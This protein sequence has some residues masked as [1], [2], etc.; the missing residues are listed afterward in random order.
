M[1]PREN[2]SC[3]APSHW[4][5]APSSRYGE[6]SSCTWFW[7]SGSFFRVSKQG[8]CFAAVEEE[9]GDKRPVELEP[10]CKADDVAP[11]DPVRS[12]HCCHAIAEAI[13]M[14][15]SAEQVPYL[16]MVAPSNSGRSCYYLHWCSW[17][18][19]FLCWPSFH[20]SSLCLRVCWWGLEVHHWCRPWD[21]WRQ[22]VGWAWAIHQWRWICGGHGVFP[23]WSSLGTSWTRWV[24]VSIPDGHLLLSRRTTWQTV[25]E[26][27]TA[28][29]LI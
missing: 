11:P 4:S 20:M 12:G 18:W 21:R 1:D 24:R 8:W 3:S 2:W 14:Q 17:Y 5:C 15:T 23:A 27:R 29:V 28:G 19:C 6:V 22:V 26:D 10:N 7:K 25:Q 13:L 9:V 16:H